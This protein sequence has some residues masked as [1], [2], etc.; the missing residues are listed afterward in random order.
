MTS[1]AQALIQ[2]GYQVLI[3][4]SSIDLLKAIFFRRN[5]VFILSL[6]SAGGAL[7]TRHSVFILHGFSCASTGILSS[8]VKNALFVVCSKFASAVVSI[9]E[10]TR[11]INSQVLGVRVT[12]VIPNPVRLMPLVLGD[13]Q[14]PKVVFLGRLDTTKGVH[15]IAA[16]M[17]RLAKDRP[18]LQCCMLGDGPAKV[19]LATEYGDQ[20]KFYGWVDLQQEDRFLD[21]STIFISLNELEP[22][23][24]TIFEAA[25]R[26]C[27]LCLPPTGGFVPYLRDYPR[28]RWLDGMPDVDS[29]SAALQECIET[30][31][32]ESPEALKPFTM[33]EHNRRALDAYCQ[34]IEKL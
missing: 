32:I 17:R 6:A 8:L 11:L 16:A 20:V 10:I 25:Q 15:L 5:S 23:G 19:E 26:G 9:S 13:H 4:S 21:T 7:L 33:D 14:R 34:I 28:V 2:S 29:V 22:F 12:H 27:F 18:Y 1:I 31:M 30:V 24:L 3:V